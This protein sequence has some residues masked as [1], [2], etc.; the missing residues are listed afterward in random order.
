MAFKILVA[1]D[2]PAIALAIRNV[3]E[4]E[5]GWEVCDD[6][7]TVDDLIRGIATYQPNV[8]V[9]DYHMPGSV[10][11]DG[12]RMLN[13]LRRAQPMPS[14]V[15]FTMMTNA[16]ILRA[17][18][19][20]P[21]Q[22]LLLKDSPLDELVKAL[23]RVE[24]GLRYIGKSAAAILAQ[25]RAFYPYSDEGGLKRPLSVR[26]TEVLRLYLTG[27]SVT[28]IAGVLSRSV[29]TISRQK[30]CAMQKLGATNDRELFDYAARQD[31]VLPVSAG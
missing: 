7:T 19:D 15:V 11:K 22:G 8:V 21:V 24:R 18:V 17:M 20:L 9:T 23:R 6:V 29:K 30:N 27:K 3:L 14:I 2:H 28:Q 4:C 13:S 16:M 1:D 26:E 25:A 5:M 31:L 10:A 12:L